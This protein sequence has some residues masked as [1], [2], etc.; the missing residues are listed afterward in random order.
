[1]PGSP[2][3]GTFVARAF[4]PEHSTGR[5]GR[6]KTAGLKRAGYCTRSISREDAK[7]RRETQGEERKATGRIRVAHPG[8][9]V[10]GSPAGGTFA[11]RAFQLLSQ[12]LS[13]LNVTARCHSSM[14]QIY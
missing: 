9:A 1:M 10:P 14:A 4:Q 11:A 13:Q 6:L 7:T 5:F 12:P 2:V 3:G 8:T